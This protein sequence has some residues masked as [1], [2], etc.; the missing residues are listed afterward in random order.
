MLRVTQLSDTHFGPDGH[1]SHG[2]LGYDTAAAFEAVLARIDQDEPADLFVITGDLADR[3]LPEEYERAA[4]ALARLPGPV[5]ILPGN[6]DFH[7]PLQVGLG[8]PGLTMPRTLR[9][10][11]WLFVLAD[12]N[13]TGRRFDSAGRLVDLESRMHDA[14]GRLGE[15]EVGWIEDVVD[16]SDAPHVFLWM[17]HPP[18]MPVESF[19]DREFDAEVEGLVSKIDRIRG[20]GAGHVHTDVIADIGG[21][22]VHVCPALTI[23]IDYTA[24]TLLPPGYRTYQF[25]PDG[26]VD[27]TAHVI[28][29]DV[30][31]RRPVHPAGMSYLKGEIGWD[32]MM[33]GLGGATPSNPDGD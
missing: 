22:P 6:H 18:S 27:S 30:W 9:V 10:G 26:T 28:D 5:A 25:Q 2:G 11:P 21:K 23:N 3:G 17:H 19:A 12:S 31:P 24:E 14:N 29:G 33:A 13:F 7:V 16:A 4:A 15:R 20:I 8:V 1:R 32:E